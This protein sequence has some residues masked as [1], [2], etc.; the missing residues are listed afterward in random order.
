M[1][2]VSPV[3]DAIHA[4]FERNALDKQVRPGPVATASEAARVLAYVTNNV[5]ASFLQHAR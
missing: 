1:H 2:V 5:F 4:A 3:R